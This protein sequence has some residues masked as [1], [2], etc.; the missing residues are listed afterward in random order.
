M[1][2][3]SLLSWNPRKRMCSSAYLFV[4]MVTS[5]LSRVLY[6]KRSIKEFI[7]HVCI[8]H[9]VDIAKLTLCYAV[10]SRA[11]LFC[12]LSRIHVNTLDLLYIACTMGP[13][14]GGNRMWNK[15]NDHGPKMNMLIFYNICLRRAVFKR[16]KKKSLTIPFYS[17]VFV[18]SSP[19]HVIKKNITSILCPSPTAKPVGPFQHILPFGELKLHG[20][21]DNFF[22][23]CRPGMS[24]P[25]TNHKFYTTTSC[26]MV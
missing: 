26:S 20:H 22:L 5:H 15:S 1:S 8:H 9:I 14:L 16:E 4:S 21:S 10:M 24:S 13:W 19:N 17:L 12:L 6:T 7:S 2:L 18:F 11:T 23:G 25:T 3:R